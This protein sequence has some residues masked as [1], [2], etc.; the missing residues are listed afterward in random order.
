MPLA[1][2]AVAIVTTLHMQATKHPQNV[3][4][5]KKVLLFFIAVETTVWIDKLL[6]FVTF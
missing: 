5:T 4:G 6:D 1:A 2:E 3:G